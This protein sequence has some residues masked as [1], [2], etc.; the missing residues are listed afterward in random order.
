MESQLFMRLDLRSPLIFFRSEPAS[1]FCRDSLSEINAAGNNL[2]SDNYRLS[3]NS[4]CK[5][6]SG[7]ELEI[8]HQTNQNQ[9]SI[10]ITAAQAEDEIV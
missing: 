6:L 5:C 9:R 3:E 8:P 2:F 10:P 7:K 1:W 4:D